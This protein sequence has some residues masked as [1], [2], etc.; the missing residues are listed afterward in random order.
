MEELIVFD[1]PD[2]SEEL[3]RRC[4]RDETLNGNLGREIFKETNDAFGVGFGSQQRELLGKFSVVCSKDGAFEN[5][6]LMKFDHIYSPI[7]HGPSCE[8]IGVSRLAGKSENEVSTDRNAKPF[9]TPDAASCSLHVVST[10][11]SA[12][13]LVVN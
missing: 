2:G 11:R 12:Q 6:K 4:L 1:T 7:I 8:G 13:N 9:Q 5:L 10:P 3:S